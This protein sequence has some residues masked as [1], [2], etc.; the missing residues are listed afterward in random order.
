MF[1]TQNNGYITAVDM[2]NM[3]VSLNPKIT[4]EQVDSI[5]A[6]SDVDGDGVINY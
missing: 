6:E 3:L 1:D 2:K 5:I 4:D